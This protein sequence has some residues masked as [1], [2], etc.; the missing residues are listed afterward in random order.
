MSLL[1]APRPPPP[2]SQRVT[3]TLPLP[4]FLTLAW[5]PVPRLGN[6]QRPS[7]G[8]QP[9]CGRS[10]TGPLCPS[11]Y[12]WCHG[13]GMAVSSPPRQLGTWC[14]IVTFLQ[15]AI[16]ISTRNKQLSVE[17]LEVQ[18][19]RVPVDCSLPPLV[20]S[21]TPLISTYSEATV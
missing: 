19:A 12:P 21:H 7:S 13:S 5:S 16:P 18:A 3:L 9:I 2:C 6:A 10:R 15:K 1:P 8:S 17:P 11:P 4:V 14:S 20:L